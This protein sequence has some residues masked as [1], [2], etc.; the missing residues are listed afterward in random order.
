MEPV[1]SIC[2]TSWNTRQLLRNCL[3]S[4]YADRDCASWEVLVVDNASRDDSP[5]MVQARFPQVE[6][7]ACCENLGFVRGSNLALQRARGRYLLLLNS[8]TRVEAGAL[9]RLVEFM[10]AHREA[11]IVGPKLL[12]EDG[13]LQLSCGISPTLG[14]ETINKLLLHKLFPFFKLGR[15]SHREIRPVG[16]VTGACLMARR[17]AVEQVGLLDSGIFMFYEDLDWCM[18]IGQCGW[19]IYY[20]PASRVVHLGGQSTRQQSREMLVVS[21]CSLFYLFHKHFG[22][23]RLQ[24]LRVLTMVEMGLRTFIWSFVF[25]FYPDRRSDSRARLWAYRRILRKCLTEK[26]YWAPFNAP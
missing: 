7:I 5:A 8:D 23:G 21:Q 19:K 15:W 16:W 10:E 17:E 12:N 18:R 25:L 13:S 14:T 6:L 22:P 3:A 9:G 2:I 4:L 20:L 24:V 26:S 11:G 1:L